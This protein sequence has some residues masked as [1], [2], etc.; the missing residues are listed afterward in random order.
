MNTQKQLAPVAAIK[1]MLVSEGMKS[2]IK[3]ALPAHVPADRF[4]RTAMTV[5]TQNPK[6]ADCNRESLFA[7]ILSAA[8]LGLM[9]ESFLG[10]AYM[11]PYKGFVQ[12]QVGYKGLIKLARQSG[13]IS[14]LS[15]DV[16]HE[17]DEF[18]VRG[19]SDPVLD[20]TPAYSAENRGDPVLVYAIVFF[21]DGGK[22]WEVISVREI[23]EIRNSSPSGNSPAW[24]G[25]WGEMAKKVAIKRLLKRCGLSAEVSNA[26][27]MDN[28]ADAGQVALVS[29]GVLEVTAIEEAGSDEPPAPV[30]VSRIESLE[31]AVKGEQRSE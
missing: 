27:A 24:R 11:V 28:A 12:L 26:V 15:A 4:I 23:E 10:E 22:Q 18:L 16:V 2:Q 8:S 17:S 13:E 21:K 9:T 1:H 14:S 25:H 29:D 30:S 20:H 7:A 3:M 5:I 19:G 6:L 31:K